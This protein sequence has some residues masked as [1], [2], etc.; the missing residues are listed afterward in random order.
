MRSIEST[1]DVGC[2]DRD[3]GVAATGIGTRLQYAH[4]HFRLQ[5]RRMSQLSS[6][7]LSAAAIPCH[8]CGYDVRA[9]PADG[10][11]PECSAAVSESHRL[12]AIPRRPAWRDADPRWRRRLL[13]GAWILALVP[14][15]SV[16]RD[17]GWAEI[18]PAPTFFKVQRPQSLNE[19][20]VAHTYEY[21][22]FCVGVVLLFSKER[23]R[24]RNRL[25]WT[26][27][28]GVI[29]SYLVFLLGI[30]TFAFIT[31]LV[32]GGIGA[33]FLNMRL[34]DQPSVTHLLVQV[35]TGYLYYGP[36]PGWLLYAS[37]VAFSSIVVLLACVPL[38]TALCSSGP[39]MWAAILLAPLALASVVQ[40][41]LA[42]QY[43]VGRL[44]PSAAGH[45]F[46]FMPSALTAGFTSLGTQRGDWSGIGLQFIMEVAK[47]FAITAIAIWLTIAQ[48]AVKR[49]RRNIR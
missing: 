10:V 27:R 39:K 11:C 26:R 15:M 14:L 9:Q 46:Y 3:A 45:F 20:F 17:S 19:S 8:A 4:L 29:T 30:P 38:Y 35:S 18:L 7:D 40:I 49:R 43:V 48:I 37:L 5:S 44:P 2:A 1:V 34:V 13:A 47:S 21:L 25:D 22:T 12:A 28:W 33:V 23:N 36:H 32:V 42:F 41:V 31:A 16:L 24:Q 6:P